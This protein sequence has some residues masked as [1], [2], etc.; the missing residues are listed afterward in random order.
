VC[1]SDLSVGVR[2]VVVHLN[3]KLSGN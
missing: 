2:V 1:S 3:S